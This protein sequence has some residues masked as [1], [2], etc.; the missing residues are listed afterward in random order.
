MTKNEL[1]VKQN[2]KERILELEK[3]VLVKQLDWPAATIASKILKMYEEEDKD[4]EMEN[5]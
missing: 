2:L 1:E 5:A 4:S 3:D